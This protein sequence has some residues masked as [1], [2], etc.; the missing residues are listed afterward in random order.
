MKQKLSLQKLI[1]LIPTLETLAHY[2][3]EQII[4]YN[5]FLKSEKPKE[6]A[7]EWYDK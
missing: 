6:D 7:E 5:A 4:K 1:N 3:C 2:A